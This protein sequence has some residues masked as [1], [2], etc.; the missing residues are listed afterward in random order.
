MGV[1][2]RAR[3]FVR[4]AMAQRARHVDAA[5]VDDA[6]STQKQRLKLDSLG[7]VPIKSREFV[8]RPLHEVR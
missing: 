4:D 1:G 2:I 8:E 5:V 6:S 3:E 7:S